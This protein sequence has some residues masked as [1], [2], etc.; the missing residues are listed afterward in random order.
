[1]Q[2]TQLNTLVNSY[3]AGELLTIT[4]MTPFLD[5]AIDDIND[6]LN[7]NYPAI[8]EF[9]AN[10]FSQYPNYDFFPDNYIRTVVA[11]GA[12]YY[13]YVTDEEGANSAPIY[14]MKYA[15]ALFKMERD[16]LPLVP[17]TWKKVGAGVIEGCASPLLDG[18]FLERQPCDDNVDGWFP[19]IRA[20]EG[21]QGIQGEQGPKG[22]E[23]VGIEKVTQSGYDIEILLTDGRLYSV[24]NLQGP[25]GIQ[26]P[27]GPIG[28]EGPMGPQGPQG[29][30]GETGA[31]GETGPQGPAGYTGARGVS[32]V[33]AALSK[34]GELEIEFETGEVITVGNVMGPQGVQGPKGDK[35]DTGATG[36]QGQRGPQGIQGIQGPEGP[37][38][39]KGDT[40]PQGPAG[41]AGSG[42]GDMLMSVYDTNGNSIVDNAERLGGQLPEYYATKAEVDTPI[43]ST[44]VVSYADVIS[45]PANAVSGQI[46]TTVKG[47]TATNIF[48]MDIN[49]INH[50]G[51]TISIN[52]SEITHT[53]TALQTL[54]NGYV[55]EQYP[56]TLNNKYYY[57]ASFLPKYDT[58]VGIYLNGTYVVKTTPSVNV[59]NTYSGIYTSDSTNTAIL[60][61]HATDTLYSVGDTWKTKDFVVVDLTATFGAG[62]EPTKEQCDIIFSNWFD[63]T[64]SVNGNF[65]LRSVGKN[66][67]DKSKTTDGYFYS[68]LGVKTTSATYCFSEKIKVHPLT[69]Y[70]CG[71]TFLNIV[72]FDSNDNYIGYSGVSQY[73][74]PSNIAYLIVSMLIS[75]KDAVQV[76]RGTTATAYEPYKESVQQINSNTELRRL[77]N[78]VRD[79]I[80]VDDRKLV[81]RVSQVVLNGSENWGKS[82]LTTTGYSGF[83][84]ENTG[85]PATTVN[86]SN[87]ITSA[88]RIGTVTEWNNLVLDEFIEVTTA[89]NGTLGIRINNAKLSTTDITGFKAWLQAHPITLIYQLATPV[90]SDIE[91]LGDLQSYESGTVYLEQTVSP[92]ATTQAEKVITVPMNLKAQVDS[93]SDSIANL[94]EQIIELKE[95]VGNGGG[96][97][98]VEHT[99]DHLE[100]TLSDGTTSMINLNAEDLWSID[101]DPIQTISKAVPIDHSDSYGA[102]G[103]ATNDLF[104][105]VKIVNNLYDDGKTPSV[106]L[107]A[108]QGAILK[109]LV[110][111]KAPIYH[112]S[113]GTTYGYGNGGTYGHVKLSDS[114]TNGNDSASSGVASTPLAVKTAYDLAN[115]KASIV[116]STSAP[117]TTLSANVLHCV[118]S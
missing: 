36:A 104:G 47:F 64:K 42:T 45:L 85:Y 58:K 118:Y 107:S 116:T 111:G 19:E 56:F 51:N 10:D 117:T 81:K 41:P 92:T 108:Y 22:D 6:R 27:E 95:D 90:V 75:N 43:Y 83:S 63:G 35:G 18:L 20:L 96:G 37:Q 5:K 86:P 73:T 50:S 84:I 57:K 39:P 93:Y 12:A 72:F 94:S 78:G 103:K 88:L 49:K 54:G 25:Q 106:V 112:A 17:D 77:P 11:F 74:T 102:Y 68:N 7:T 1:M 91:V 34:D 65:T 80:D 15:D 82:S 46:D 76:E 69:T 21:P 4:Q 109:G 33:G 87:Y 110:D 29:E 23:G 55:L 71:G 62:N 101:D 48:S 70:K 99:H 61:T 52:G 24:K 60:L 8:S 89:N 59:W 26:G 3:L 9:N 98:P 2:L 105:H 53:V 97:V 100:T 66:L 30:K 114:V 38:G 67:F 13:F 44:D 40:G 31:K 115:T 113:T 16:Y 14:Q 32:I 28:P 79:E